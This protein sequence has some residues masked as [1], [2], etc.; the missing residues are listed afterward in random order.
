VGKPGTTGMI[1]LQKLGALGPDWRGK[2]IAISLSPGWFFTPVVS[3]HFYEGSF[4]LLA[5]SEMVCSGAL[6]F[7]LKHDIVLRMLQFRRTFARSPLLELARERLASG[8][9]MDGTVFHALWPMRKMQNTILDLQDDFEA[10]I[11]I[12][13]TAQSAIPLCAWHHDF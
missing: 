10:L 1:I 7:E 5:A 6:D 8:R 2:M 11:H 9:W 13:R 12:Y 4:S 3:P